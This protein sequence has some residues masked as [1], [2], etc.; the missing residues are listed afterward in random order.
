MNFIDFIILIPIAWFAFKGFRKGL[1]IEI[2]TLAGLILGIYLGIYFSD[3]I[4]GYLVKWFGVNPKFTST[5]SFVI[6]LVGIMVLVY[7][8][9]KSLE[10]LVDVIALGLFNKVL[11]AF[12]GAIKMLLIFCIL[13]YIIIKIDPNKK[14]VSSE[15]RNKSLLFNPMSKLSE[16][17]LPEVKEF[18]KKIN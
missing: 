18:T 10:K 13:I 11:G 3:F 14:I 2:A 8:L 5:I 1:I 17:I 12:F 15:V 7:L 16:K 9:G 4:S 6:I